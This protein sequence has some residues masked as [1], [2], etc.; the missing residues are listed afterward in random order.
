MKRFAYFALLLL[1]LLPVKMSAQYAQIAG[2][3]PSLIS[4]ALTGSLNYRG[5]VEF[6]ALPGLG[7]N[8]ANDISITTS[9]GFQYAT[10]F[11]MGVGT[12]VDVMMAKQ[13]DNPGFNYGEYFDHGGSKTK[14]MIPL[15]TDFRFNIGPQESTSFFID[16]KLGA[17]WLIGNSYLEMADGYLSTGTQFFMRPSLGVRIPVSQQ[18]PKQ[19]FN[20]GMTYQLLT[21]NNNYY[22]Y[23]NSL[24]LNNVGF[25]VSYEW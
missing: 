4:P 19:A 11:Y 24:T 1:V 5:S 10:W 13:T 9:Q 2:Q 23:S 20:I 25:S 6:S 22:R 7:H 3:L 12:G 15:F 16:I 21:S 14:V 8:R 17:S 18:N